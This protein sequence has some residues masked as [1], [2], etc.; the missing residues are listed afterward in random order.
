MHV[1]RQLDAWRCMLCD[2]QHMHAARFVSYSTCRAV[3]VCP[4]AANSWRL[5]PAAGVKA[6]VDSSNKA[7][8]ERGYV[9]TLLGRHRPIRELRSGSARERGDGLR[10]V[11]NSM[12]QGSAADVVKLVMC[13]WDDWCG[14]QGA[15]APARLVAQ[16]HDELLFEV[17]GGAAAVQQVTQVRGAGAGLC[18]W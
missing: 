12:I 15:A 14:A 7:A 2:T 6:F 10:K 9:N 8:T 11:V 5:A 13:K 1:A 18:A 17:Q 3:G 4:L 16:I